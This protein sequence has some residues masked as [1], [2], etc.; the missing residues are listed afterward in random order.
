MALG[1]GMLRLR[2]APLSMTSF[3]VMLSE[4]KHPIP[5]KEPYNISG[6]LNYQ[7]YGQHTHAHAQNGR[8]TE[9]LFPQQR[10]RHIVQND[11]AAAH[12]REKHRARHVLERGQ[13][14]H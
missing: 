1:S 10:C 13:H 2:F 6:L 4:A 14:G 12:Q 3:L 9:R 8:S 11:H 7:N 5:P